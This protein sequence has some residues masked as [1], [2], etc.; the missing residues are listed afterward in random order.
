MCFIDHRQLVALQYLSPSYNPLIFRRQLNMTLTL[1]FVSQICALVFISSAVSFIKI[2]DLT[3]TSSSNT[4]K[5]PVVEVDDMNERIVSG[6]ESES[7]PVDVEEERSLARDTTISF[8]GMS[9]ALKDDR[10]TL[11]MR[12]ILR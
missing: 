4:S 9:C 8:P 7:G 10:Q 6:Y 1:L 3:S 12:Q 2:G 5:T 11:L